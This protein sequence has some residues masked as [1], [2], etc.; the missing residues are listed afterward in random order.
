MTVF[1]PLSPITVQMQ[2]TSV[3]H[4]T[5]GSPTTAVFLQP[6]TPPQFQSPDL[7]Q[8]IQPTT[9]FPQIDPQIIFSQGNSPT[10]NEKNDVLQTTEN[11][12]KV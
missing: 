6:D 12:L 3:A 10:K 8:V 9:N 7:F 11:M 5:F 2:N 1:V 4:D